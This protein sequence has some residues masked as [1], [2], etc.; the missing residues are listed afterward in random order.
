MPPV[1]LSEIKAQD[2]NAPPGYTWSRQARRYR[3][4]TTG[5]FVS[6]SGV[7]RLLDA[8]EDANI[9]LIRSLTESLRDGDLPAPAWYIAVQNQLRRLHVQC[10]ALGAGG[11]DNLRPGDFIRI[12]RKLREEMDRLI[13]FGQQ[14]GAGLLSDAQIDNRLTMYAGTARIQFYKAQ[15][16]PPTGPGEMVIEKRVLLPAEH[17]EWCLYLV[18]LGWQPFGVLPYPGETVADWTEDSCL[19]NCRCR[20]EQRVIKAADRDKWIDSRRVPLWLAG[21]KSFFAIRYAYRN[22]AAGKAW[23]A[24]NHPRHPSG[25]RVDP[26]SGA[27]GGR[28]APKNKNGETSLLWEAGPFAVRRAAEILDAV[29]ELEGDGVT[30]EGSALWQGFVEM[31]AGSEPFVDYDYQVTYAADLL[32]AGEIS[33]GDAIYVIAQQSGLLSYR[34]FVRLTAAAGLDADPTLQQ[35]AGLSSSVVFGPEEYRRFA[36]TA[37]AAGQPPDAVIDALSSAPWTA[38][39]QAAERKYQERTESS[40]SVKQEMQSAAIEVAQEHSTSLGQY[41]E[42]LN[43]IAPGKKWYDAE[44]AFTSGAVA[45]RNG[46]LWPEAKAQMAEHLRPQREQEDNRRLAAYQERA[47]TDPAAA[48]L[49]ANFQPRSGITRTE[50]AAA[51]RGY[52][53]NIDNAG[54]IDFREAD[55][56][57]AMLTSLS[58][59]DVYDAI[60]DE[61]LDFYKVGVLPLEKI[62]LDGY[63][64]YLKRHESSVNTSLYQQALLSPR[65]EI[66]A[67]P[68]DLATLAAAAREHGITPPAFLQEAAIGAHHVSLEQLAAEGV[69]VNAVAQMSAATKRR[70]AEAGTW[71]QLQA[72]YKEMLPASA[73]VV[74]R[75]LNDPSVPMPRD[76]RLYPL[77]ASTDFSDYDPASDPAFSRWVAANAPGFAHAFGADLEQ[78][79]VELVNGGTRRVRSTA[80]LEGGKGPTPPT[81]AA[82]LLDWHTAIRQEAGETKHSVVTALSE[83]S[84]VDYETTNSIIAAWANSSNKNAISIVVQERAEALFGAQ[85]SAWQAGAHQTDRR[86]TG[87]DIPPADKID[88]VLRSMYDRTQEWFKARGVTHVELWRGVDLQP[89]EHAKISASTRKVAFDDNALSSWSLNHSIASL[90]AGE[91]RYGSVLRSVIPVQRIISTALTG[92]GCLTEDEYVVLGAPAGVKSQATWLPAYGPDTNYHAVIENKSPFGYELVSWPKP[93]TK[94][95]DELYN[96][97]YNLEASGKG[98]ALPAAKGWDEDSHPRHPKGTPVDGETGAGGGRFAPKD[99]GDEEEDEYDEYDEYDERGEDESIAD[100]IAAQVQL[101]DGFF[102]EPGWSPHSDVNGFFFD[103]F[104]KRV[105]SYGFSERGDDIHIELLLLDE[106]VQGY[107]IALHVL[108]GVVQYAEAEGYSTVSL[109]ADITIGRYTWARYGFQY[110]DSSTGRYVSRSFQEW[111]ETH[112]INEPEIGWPQFKTPQ[113][114]IAYDIPGITVKGHEIYNKHVAD[115]L[116]MNVGKAFMFDAAGHGDWDGI[117]AVGDLKKALIEARKRKGRDGTVG[118]GA[119]TKSTN[120]PKV[121]DLDGLDLDGMIIGK[122]EGGSDAFFWSLM[123]DGDAED[124]DLIAPHRRFRPPPQA[125]AAQA[126]EIQ[127]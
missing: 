21:A 75:M 94:S 7:Y 78:A 6:Y 24:E 68:P 23:N 122:R 73:Q 22:M 30:V 14:I 84:G 58:E 80:Y 49:A 42:H 18:D 126:G 101:S 111:A 100:R 17:C 124:G 39:D 59:S 108:E 88:A 19:S 25:T 93:A 41:F 89:E 53:D 57:Q 43:R 37:I 60:Y 44:F 46:V 4:A 29:R 119:S 52:I 127:E 87:K 55:E 112:E 67:N 102:M 98:I 3:D 107:G 35:A 99:E 91:S 40:W 86:D 54:G 83:R 15:R 71:R 82:L 110:E 114:V 12:D 64:G 56:R 121:F 61:N 105:G 51:L 81:Q 120:T 113:D 45:A 97:A 34:D 92:F 62:T 16:K 13:V 9:R 33:L 96:V 76:H 116:I 28:F 47:K 10:A 31:L 5:R 26:A 70:V 69:G 118:Q 77:V 27:G 109:L 36:G 72:V 2:L 117:I 66:G 106:D 20:M 85:R 50:N 125:N 103:A 1:L 32:R 90:F 79:A 74:E 48:L 65:T 63:L 115:D 95:I 11:F 123:L 8:N 38:N 104:G